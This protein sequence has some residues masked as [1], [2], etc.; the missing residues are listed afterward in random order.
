MGFIKIKNLC[1]VK[2][3]VKRMRKKP[4]P[5]IKYL[6]KTHVIKDCYGNI[7]NSLNSVIKKQTIWLKNGPKTL[8][9]MSPKKIYE[10]Q[11]SAQKDVPHHMSLGDCKL[12][13]Q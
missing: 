1:S 4:Q 5:G 2:D 8:T 13:Q 7:R 10:Q 3:N 12:K 11:I 6:Q 9:N